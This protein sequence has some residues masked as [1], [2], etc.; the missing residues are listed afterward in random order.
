MNVLKVCLLLFLVSIFPLCGSDGF[1]LEFDCDDFVYNGNIAQGKRA[2]GEIYVPDTNDPIT[3]SYF[4]G[5]IKMKM[6]L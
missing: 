3:R 4:H 5:V 1:Q 2:F 6:A